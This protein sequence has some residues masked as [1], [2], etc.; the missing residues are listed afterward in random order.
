MLLMVTG[1]Y[2]MNEI[3]GTVQFPDAGARSESTQREWS[4]RN[5]MNGIQIDVS[6]CVGC[7]SCIKACPAKDANVASFDAEQQKMVI[8]IDD[9][10]CIKCGACI[11]ACTHGARSY[12]DDTEAFFKALAAGEQIQLIVAPAIQNTFG[13]NWKQVVAWLRQKGVKGAYDVSF[14]ADICT[15]A[16][17]RYLGQHPDAKLISQP[18]AAIVNYVLKQRP[19]LIDSLSPVQSPMLCL[20]VYMKKYLQ[21]PGKIAALS[22]CIAKTDEFEQTGLVSYNVTLRHLKEYVESH[23]VRLSDVRVSGSEPVFDGFPGVGGAIYPEPAGL[24]ENLLAH[25]P[26]LDVVN[27]EGV[28]KVYP[29]L[30]EYMDAD[31]GELPQVFDV[32]SCEFGCNDGPG[33]GE[34][35]RPFRTRKLMQQKTLATV[36]SP[37]FRLRAGK[38]AQFKKF[39]RVLKLGDFTRGYDRTLYSKY[40][41]TEQEIE[42]AYQRLRKT[43]PEKRRVNCHSCGF[44]SCND[45]A[46]AIAR[47]I[48]V[49]E[50]CRM[51]VMDTIEDERQ[52][53]SDVNRQVLAMTE[54][55]LHVFETLTQSIE[56]VRSEATDIG[57]IGNESAGNIT[58]VSENLTE[59][60]ALN[61]S[62][63]DGMGEINSATVNYEKMTQ[64][65]K[66][67]AD[68][69]NLLSIN[70][71]VEAARAGEAGRGFAVVAGSIRDLSDTS[72]ASVKEA[73]TNGDRVADAIE[74]IDAT[75]EKFL[76]ETGRLIA[77]VDEAA[78]SVRS[79]ADKTET[80]IASVAEVN[81]MAGSVYEMIERTKAVLQA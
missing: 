47:G 31:R 73:E 29:E 43:T 66:S 37:K 65:V 30:M 79:A 70:A 8:T 18:C 60:R 42:A 41:P 4:E 51:Y 46:Y 16:H 53:V 48:N 38:D 72:L 28:D 33:T 64:S 63:A 25:M 27:S 21:L 7:N 58:R 20:A 45:M 80:I 54:D 10:K 77:V 78:G 59:L 57:G 35:F 15:W 81:A 56:N 5:H 76:S 62:I 67:I 49:P 39:D 12:T 61:Q 32:L 34:D 9:G 23:G 17:L 3:S 14:G 50:N 40:Y 26:E 13:A 6:K 44:A 75:L 2:I 11:S 19:K 69:I 71:S 1:T 22:P 24:R 55:L 74:R 68:T 52:R 36:G